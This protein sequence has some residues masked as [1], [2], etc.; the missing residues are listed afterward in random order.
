MYRYIEN[1]NYPSEIEQGVGVGVARKTDKKGEESMHGNRQ[2]KS[3]KGWG[4]PPLLV[5]RAPV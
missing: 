4:A 1:G 3:Q 5:L 2:R